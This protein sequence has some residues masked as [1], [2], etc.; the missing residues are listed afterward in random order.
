[1]NLVKNNGVFEFRCSYH[2]R[3]IPRTAGFRWDTVKKVW[4][5]NSV[6]IAKRLYP[7]ASED[8]FSENNDN[9]YCPISLQE[10][11]IFGKNYY[12]CICDYEHRSIPKS[13]GFWFMRSEMKWVSQ[14]PECAVRLK[15]YASDATK[16]KI[17]NDYEKKMKNIECSKLVDVDLE[18]PKPEGLDYLGFQK[19][20][21][22]YAI[23]RD[24]TLIADEMGLGKTIQAIGVYNSTDSKKWL[25]VCPAYLKGNWKK[26]II[27]WSVKDCSVGIVKSGNEF[28][29]TDVVIINYEIM[30]K[31][32]NQLRGI[33]WDLFTAD[34]V[35]YCKNY[36]SKRT[37]YTLGGQILIKDKTTG[38]SKLVNVP[39]ITSKRAILLTGTPILNR[40]VE[41]WPIINFLDGNKFDKFNSFAKRYCAA[42]QTRWGL[43]ITGASNL[44]EL[45]KELR[46]RFMIRRLK[47]DVLTELPKKMRQVIEIGEEKELV[48]HELNQA[49]AHFN[50][51]E[52]LVVALEV[53]KASDNKQ[54]YVDAVNALKEGYAA[55]FNEIAK[56]RKEV[57]ERKVKYVVEHVADI[58]ESGNKVVVFTHHID[59]ADQI[60]EEIS[61]RGIVSV[62]SHSKKSMEEREQAVTSFQED[63]KVRV[64]IGTMRACG[65]GITLT[66]ANHVVFAEIDWVPAIISQAEDRSHRYGQTNSVLV[67]HIVFEGS[68][69]S[70]MVCKVISKQ[71]VIDAALDDEI[72]IQEPVTI[73]LADVSIKEKSSTNKKNVGSEVTYSDVD[74]IEDYFKNNRNEIQ[75]V[76]NAILE[77]KQYCDGAFQKDDM[78]FNKIDAR[79]AEKLLNSG[80]M[81]S[82]EA[83]YALL[84]VWKYKRQLSKETVDVLEKIK[85]HKK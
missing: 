6:S 64:F 33:K 49:Q 62:V 10:M 7:Y 28:P 34:E 59:I 75:V 38:K 85:N 21:I 9:Q 19:A 30:E 26:E 45:Q 60:H 20:G 32:S 3:E 58:A 53:S 5:T 69:D 37:V 61:K 55:M 65:T 8:I 76:E 66:A 31:F 47:K 29:D 4:Y 78:G 15:D 24:N 68:L 1:M 2:E 46:S 79:V 43:D 48:S 74:I 73:T 56:L 40:P 70:Y 22:K 14:D 63:E 81:N 39:K 80:V 42:H 41:L 67:Q 82:R 50:A 72:V 25:V 77:I 83:A 23:E 71:E 18:L 36:K 84:M 11:V 44:D 17:Q 52:E 54:D 35:H 57:A 27:K 13:A 12:V 51:I 16:I